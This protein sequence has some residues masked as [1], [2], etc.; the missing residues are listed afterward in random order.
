MATLVFSK[1]IECFGG[2]KREKYQWTT[3]FVQDYGELCNKLA[4]HQ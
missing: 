3:L 4:Q 1:Q 2:K